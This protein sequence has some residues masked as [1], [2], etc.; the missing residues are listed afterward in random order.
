MALIVSSLVYAVLFGIASALIGWSQT[1]GTTS[2]GSDDDYFT[3]T[4]NLNGGG[5]ALLILGY[6]VAYVVGRSPSPRSCPAAWIWPTGG[7]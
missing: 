7:R 5:L 3:F 1:M 4:A 2:S 6:L